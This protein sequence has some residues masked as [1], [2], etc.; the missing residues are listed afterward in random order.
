MYIA[1]VSELGFE[2]ENQI[3]QFKTSQSARIKVGKF[4]AELP[5]GTEIPGASLEERAR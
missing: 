4:I 3:N 2:L 5:E 1:G